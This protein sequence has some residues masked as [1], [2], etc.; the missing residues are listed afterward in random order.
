MDYGQSWSKRGTLTM[1]LNAEKIDYAEKSD[2]ILLH[3]NKEFAAFRGKTCNYC[4][5]GA[6]TWTIGE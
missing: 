5:N 4:K 6:S 3:V 1:W 2:V